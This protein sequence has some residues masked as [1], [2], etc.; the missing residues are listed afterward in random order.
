M[1]RYLVTG[2]CGFLGSHL[3]DSLI[4][5]GDEVFCIDS[6]LIGRTDNIKH[7]LDNK[8]FHLSTID[9]RTSYVVPDVDGVFHLA[10][11][12]APPETYKHPECTLEVND[13]VTQRLINTC[14]QRSIPLLY[15]SSIKVADTIDFQSAYIRGKRLG[16][17]H[18]NDYPKSKIARLGNIY[19]PRMAPD[20]GRVIPTFIRNC[21]NNHPL[22]IW[23]DGSQI[24]SF[25][26]VDDCIKAL[27]S[28]MDKEVYGTIE[29]GSSKKVTIL[30]LALT[31]VKTLQID[32]PLSFE[33]A[34]GAIIVSNSNECAANRT[35]RALMAKQR[36]V[37][38]LSKAKKEL[39][40]RP[41]IPLNAGLTMTYQYYKHIL[42][43]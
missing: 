11:P 39:A 16:E 25:C 5:R 13:T 32:T 20:D 15:T 1:P 31:I 22:C 17:N 4:R 6:L 40:W 29:I 21:I 2:G 3:C 37:P 9:C 43:G 7:L 24:D 35:T 34:G 38:D 10:S 14:S 30:E 23:G 42:G 33:C 28:F 12:T 27:L 26:F 19:G 36:K 18:C 8:L 41:K